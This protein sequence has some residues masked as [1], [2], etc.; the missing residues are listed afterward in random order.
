[1]TTD[2]RY[3]RATPEVVDELRSAFSM[4]YILKRSDLNSDQKIAVL[5]I[6]DEVYNYLETCSEEAK[7]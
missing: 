6:L 7:R 1:M 5:M 4:P 3:P 2:K